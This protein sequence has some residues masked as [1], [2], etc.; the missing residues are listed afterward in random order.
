MKLESCKGDVE[1]VHPATMTATAITT[2]SIAAPIAKLELNGYHGAPPL[3][4][5]RREAKQEVIERH[6]SGLSGLEHLISAPLIRNH[7]CAASSYKI[8][9]EVQCS[10]SIAGRWR[11]QRHVDYHHEFEFK[12]CPSSCSSFHY[13]RH[14]PTPAVLPP[15][16]NLLHAHIMARLPPRPV[17]A[18]PPPLSGRGPPPGQGRKCIASCSFLTSD[19]ALRLHVRLKPST[20]SR[21]MNLTTGLSMLPLSSLNPN[22]VAPKPVHKSPPKGP[23]AME[24]R[25][26][27]RNLSG[28]S[29][30]TST[31]AA[32]VSTLLSAPPTNSLPTGVVAKYDE[33][34]ESV[35]GNGDA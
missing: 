3:L 1:M 35:D 7:L 11:D 13:I 20:A 25:P 17:V 16:P 6:L 31:A 32:N 30:T 33:R 18:P 26:G 10:S 23:R 8:V 21:S 9:G 28:S 27:P 14:P 34:L 2:T 5:Q 15:R 22:C 4:S 12:T 29:T 24:S 19:F